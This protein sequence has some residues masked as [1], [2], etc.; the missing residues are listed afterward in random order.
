MSI[1]LEKFKFVVVIRVVWGE[2]EMI[3]LLPLKS[4]NFSSNNTVGFVF[5]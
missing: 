3:A 1:F 4:S 2:R 5:T